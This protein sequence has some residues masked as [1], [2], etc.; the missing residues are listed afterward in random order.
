MGDWGL[1]GLSQLSSNMFSSKDSL[2]EN[3]ILKSDNPKVTKL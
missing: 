1:E 3:L 2:S